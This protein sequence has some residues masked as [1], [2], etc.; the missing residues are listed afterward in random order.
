MES[1][2]WLSQLKVVSSNPAHDKIYV[3]QQY[4]SV[5][6]MVVFFPSSPVSS[7]NKT[8]RQ[9]IVE[10]LVKVALNTIT[11]LKTYIGFEP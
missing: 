1:N 5:T 9:N 10:I 11:I 8:E 7:T 6:C 3:I 4:M 2:K